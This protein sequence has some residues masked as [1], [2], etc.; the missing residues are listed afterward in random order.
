[1]N[2]NRNELK[3]RVVAWL[4]PDMIKTMEAMMQ[5][6]AMKNHTEFVSQ[7][8]DFYIGYLSSQNSTAF[9]SQNLLG[10]IQGTLQNTENRVANNLF[11]LSVEISMMMHLLAATLEVTDDELRSLRGRCVAEVKKTRGK[12][13]LDDAVQFQQG[14]DL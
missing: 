6:K 10:A 5:E 4:Y 11:R 1:M 2:E 8:V 3:Q 12:I 7:A 14:A 9:L 13:K